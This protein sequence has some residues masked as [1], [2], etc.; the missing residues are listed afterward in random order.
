MREEILLQGG[1]LECRMEHLVNGFAAPSRVNSLWVR[2]PSA[3]RLWY[4]K[5]SPL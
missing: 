2:Y 1:E 4:Q 3:R 5:G